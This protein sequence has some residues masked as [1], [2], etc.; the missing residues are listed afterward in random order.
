MMENDEMIYT[1]I[2]QSKTGRVVRSRYTAT[3]NRR[4][5]WASA[6]AMG[7]SNGECLIAL[8]P[9]DHP[10]HTHESVFSDAPNTELKH[11]DVFEVAVESDE[12]VYEMT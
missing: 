10:V 4:E 3:M 12:N 9:G 7:E 11:H 6:A 5:A 2:F 1:A 8:V